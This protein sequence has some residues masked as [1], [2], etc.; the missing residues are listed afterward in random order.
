MDFLSRIDLETLLKNTLST[1][2]IILAALFVW[3]A[4]SRALTLLEKRPR[5]SKSLLLPVRLVLRYA[6]VIV[7]ILL[8]ISAYGIPIGNFWTFVST[9]L[10]LIAIGFVAVW[11]VL[12]N[13]SAAFFL[14]MFQPFRVG[15]YVRIVG[16]DVKGVVIDINFMFTTL[17][18]LKGD[19]YTVPNNLF[20]QK[21][22]LKPVDKEAQ[23]REDDAPVP[24]EGK[25]AREPDHSQQ[26]LEGIHLPSKGPR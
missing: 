16:E 6:V 9:L 15:D 17:Q 3:V 12:S 7:A 11:S 26:N 8:I 18:S 14:L 21:S 22:M 23:E 2:V 13:F 20:F 10:G 24:D 19:V 1:I 4:I 25:Q 5:L